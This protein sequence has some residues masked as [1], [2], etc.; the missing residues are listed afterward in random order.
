VGRKRR[1]ADGDVEL[2]ERRG[3]VIE[4]VEEELGRAI[5]DVGGEWIER[6]EKLEKKPGSGH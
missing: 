2:D 5:E 3:K 6:A 1:A 4:L